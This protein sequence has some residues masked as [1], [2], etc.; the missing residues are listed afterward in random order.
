[1]STQ[2]QTILGLDDIRTGTMEQQAQSE[3]RL[4]VT[5]PEYTDVPWLTEH[6]HET[7]IPAFWWRYSEPFQRLLAEVR[8]GTIGNLLAI[9]LKASLPEAA[10]N[11]ICPAGVDICQNIAGSELLNRRISRPT[12]VSAHS[13]MELRFESGLFASCVQIAQMPTRPPSMHLRVVGDTGIL[14]AELYGPMVH[15]SSEMGW[16]YQPYMQHPMEIL[17]ESRHQPDELFPTLQQA[18]AIAEILAG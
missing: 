5:A 9:K 11:A 3:G 12:P 10:V 17:W 16:Q 7:G 2:N 14:Q 6:L 13:I 8:N 15:I 4:L 1:M 18:L